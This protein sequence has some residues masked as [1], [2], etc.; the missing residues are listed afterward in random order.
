MPKL[1]LPGCDDILEEIEDIALAISSE[2]P[3]ILLDFIPAFG[4]NS[5]R[6]TIGPLLNPV[7]FPST[8]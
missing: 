6:V 3:I 2:S 8:P 4:I 7:I 5:K 1:V